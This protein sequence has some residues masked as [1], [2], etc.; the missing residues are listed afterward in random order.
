MTN[1]KYYIK[2]IKNII[3]YN[4]LNLEP[5]YITQ[6][7]FNLFKVNSNCSFLDPIEFIKNI[8]QF[9]RLLQFLRNQ[10]ASK[11]YL[12]SDNSTFKD[13]LLLTDGNNSKV[14]L[15]VLN[16]FLNESNLIKRKEKCFKK[17]SHLYLYAN[18]NSFTSKY[19]KN[20]FEKNLF[21]ITSVNSNFEN[22]NL[23]FY[24]L[25]NDLHEINKIFFLVLLFK[26]NL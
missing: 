6:D 7:R 18:R 19:F 24:K 14:S 22:N 1:K 9:I 15:N 2:S 25:Y 23:G 11:I 12:E 26:K 8:K 21:L 17:I 16:S 13:L 10:N 3:N 4:L 20:L 5:K